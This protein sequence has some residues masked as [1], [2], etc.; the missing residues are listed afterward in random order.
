MRSEAG[1]PCLLHVTSVPLSLYL[2][3]LHFDLRILCPD[4]RLLRPD[5]FLLFADQRLLFF[6][7]LDQQCGEPAVI[8]APG[9]LAILLPGNHLGDD[10]ADFLGNHTHFVLAIRLQVVGDAAE[11]LDFPE[12]AV[13]R[14]DVGLPAA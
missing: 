14:V 2:H 11:L 1:N 10:G 13:Q 9:V 5:L 6:C 4:L 7:G 3:L 12:R 8:D